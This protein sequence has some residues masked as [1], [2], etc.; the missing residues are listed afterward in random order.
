[1]GPGAIVYG[2]SR[3]KSRPHG[4]DLAVLW[5]AGTAMSVPPVTTNARKF[6]NVAAWWAVAA[7]A[8]CAVLLGRYALE[9][10]N[11]ESEL[12]KII[13]YSTDGVIVCNAQ[14]QVV[15]ANDAVSIMTGYTERD[16][17]ERGLAQIIP[18]YLRDKHAQGIE[19]AKVKSDRGV[20]GVLYRAIYPVM[21]KDGQP[22]LCMVSVG[23][24]LHFG[25]PQ[26]FAFI[27]PI[28]VPSATP[29]KAEDPAAFSV[30][31]PPQQN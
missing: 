23:S 12:V 21:R 8:L 6:R 13:N 4:H 7:S 29:K 25:G 17:A 10:N 28:H 11:R 19:R 3:G 16:L 14:G 24:V 15:Y 9:V 18:E 27:A 1:M 20:E 22:I 31:P 26:F 5:N 30:V 2:N